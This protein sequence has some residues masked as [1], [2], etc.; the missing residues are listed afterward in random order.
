[1]LDDD[2][3]VEFD[4]D[5]QD[6]REHADP[7][8]EAWC[9]AAQR[10]ADCAGLARSGREASS[11]T[12]LTW[13]CRATSRDGLRPRGTAS[14]QAVLRRL[15]A[16]RL[17]RL[18]TT[19]R[20]STRTTTTTA[21]GPARASPAPRHGAVRHRKG[22][23]SSPTTSCCTTPPWTTTTPLGL[24]ATAP[25]TAPQVHRAVAAHACSPRGAR[26]PAARGRG[27]RVAGHPG[28]AAE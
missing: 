15:R 19:P 8:G 4:S 23:A 1:M 2:S 3:E 26:R 9:V 27:Q 10:C 14:R 21:R 13:S 22:A 17:P 20:T 18:H 5:S 11:P 7:S 12:R 28:G 16:H 25:A 6:E 24:R